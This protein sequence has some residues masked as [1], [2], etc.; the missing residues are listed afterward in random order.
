MLSLL[1]VA[2]VLGADPAPIQLFSGK[3]L[4]HWTPVNVTPE[5]FT[6]KD[7]MIYCTG[8]PTGLLRTNEMF[9]NYV[10]EL[11]WKHLEKQGNAGLFVW[12]DG[13]PAVGVPF[14]RAIE[15]QIMVGSEADWYTCDGD[16]FPI[17]GAKMTPDHPRTINGTL[18]DRSYPTSKTTKPTDWNHYKVVCNNGT[19]ELSINGVVV[20]SAKNVSPR[21]GYICLESEGT[22]VQFKNI[23]LTP[24][25]SSNAAAEASDANGWTQLFAGDFRDWNFTSAHEGHFVASGNN[26]VFDGKGEDL[27]SKKSYKNFELICDWRWTGKGETAERPVVNPDGS[28]AVDEQGKPKTAT[29][30][31]AGDSG[32]YLRGSSK[33]QV[34]IWCWPVG[35]GEVYGYRTD[36]A[37]NEKV[38]AGVTP[39]VAADKPIGQWNRFHIT[40]KGKKLS[41]KLNDKQVLEDALLP[42]VDAAGPIALQKHD[43]AIEFTNIFVRELP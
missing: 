38:R 24:L 31:D 1:I 40:M 13:L 17:W 35:S 28:N 36:N 4:S 16:I 6:V 21:N 29:V 2:A 30:T 8:K 22:P 41:V 15:V 3:D 5:T 11:D 37:Q 33:S 43:G 27:W 9:E 39:K 32:I 7:E 34:N 23:T 10:L 12:S 26:I 20:N 18:T 25:P 14:S 19:I 42:D